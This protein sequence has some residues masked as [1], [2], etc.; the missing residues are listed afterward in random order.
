MTTYKNLPIFFVFFS[1]LSDN[2]NEESGGAMDDDLSANS[3][4][5]SDPTED[6]VVS[7]SSRDAA[8]DTQ[9]ASNTQSAVDLKTSSEDVAPEANREPVEGSNTQSAVDTK[10]SP[11]EVAPETNREPIEE[12]NTQSAVDIK[13]SAEDVAPETNRELVEESN[14]QISY[15]H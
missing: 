10:T 11:E 3:E 6:I 13:T 1:G 8:K 9:R 2:E 5:E 14:T 15:R 4:A 12:S 7:K